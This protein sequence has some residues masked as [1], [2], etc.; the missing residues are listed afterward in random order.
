MTTRIKSLIVVLFAAFAVLVSAGAASAAPPPATPPPDSSAGDIVCA[1]IS[2][3]VPLPGFC[4]V[5][6]PVID[7]GIAAA[8]FASDPLGWLASKMAAGATSMLAQVST[9][10][11]E[12]TAPD[13]SV[14]WWISAYQK[15]FAIGTVLFGFVLLV[16]LVRTA[17]GRQ[18]G[19]VW[20]TSMGGWVVAYFAGVVFGPLVGQLMIN[21]FGWLASGI[22]KQWGSTSTTEAFT[23]VN[24]AVEVTSTGKGV[25][26]MIGA[27][28]LLLGLIIACF[29]VFI[30]LALQMTILYL[31]SALF[32]IAFVWVLSARHRPGA[33]KIPTLFL[34]LCAAKPLM[35]LL[36]GIGLDIVNASLFGPAEDSVG[37]TLA[38]MI[39]AV[40]VFMIAAFA[41]M[42]LLKFAPVMPSGTAAATGTGAPAA[43]TGQPSRGSGTGQGGSQTSA[44][45]GMRASRNAGAGGAAKA[46]AAKAGASGAAGTAAAPVA[47]VAAIGS[48]ASKKAGA[49]ASSA[50]QPGSPAPAAPAG[51]AGASPAVPDSQAGTA[52]AVGTAGAGTAGASGAGAAAGGA[53]PASAA[54]SAPGAAASAQS[55]G[56]APTTQQQPPSAPVPAGA[57]PAGAG[58]AAAPAV[59]EPQWG[60]KP[61]TAAAKLA[62]RVTPAVRAATAVG[63]SVAARA[64]RSGHDVSNRVGGDQPWQ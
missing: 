28:I 24:A 64:R 43:G 39:M 42:M 52:G 5:T 14:A 6:A 10:A 18:D 3:S 33:F 21:G 56:P 60:S 57:V 62:G 51:P 58:A 38:V 8:D 1:T 49:A 23:Q 2:A 4:N 35:F 29:F 15:G 9:W 63:S 27:L 53:G 45:A 41:P 13:L 7:A 30:S 55:A 11:N 34:G 61:S 25:G 48:A 16:Q 22:I 46:G 19:H 36:L 31:S 47:A 26:E 17:S 44:L 37:R 54:A 20:L 50:G 40:S 59:Q 12:S 32:A